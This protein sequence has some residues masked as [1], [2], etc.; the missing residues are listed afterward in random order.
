MARE[1]RRALADGRGHARF[2]LRRAAEFAAV[3]PDQGDGRARR[4]EGH[5]AGPAGLAPPAL[6]AHAVRS[7]HGSSRARTSAGSSMALR[8]SLSTVTMMNWALAAQ[9]SP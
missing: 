7:C 5:D 6:P 4:A 8:V 1:G 3:V 2:R 9:V